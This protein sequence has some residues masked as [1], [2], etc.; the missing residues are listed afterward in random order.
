MLHVAAH[1]AD[2][3]HHV[4]D[5]VRAGERSSQVGRQTEACNSKY[6]IESLEQAAGYAARFVFQALREIAN[7]SLGLRGIVELP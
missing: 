5:D 2:G 7:Q 1:P 4:L 6:L 3:A